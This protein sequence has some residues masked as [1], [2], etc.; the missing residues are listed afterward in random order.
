MR[1][2]QIILAVIIA[3][4]VA[5]CGGSDG[6]AGS[7]DGD[8]S[9]TT[10]AE[11]ETS[12]TSSEAD[13]DEPDEPAEEE[14][15]TGGGESTGMATVDG[16]EYVFGANGPA[17]TCDPDFFGGFFAVLYSPDLSQTLSVE[18]WP[19]GAGE[20]RVNTGTLN[21]VAPDG[22]ELDL[23]ADPEDSWPVAEAGSTFIDEFTIDGN[24]ARGTG[25]FINTEV[26]YGE[27]P[28]EPVTVDFEI[29]CAGE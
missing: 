20:G 11:Q 21:L 5:A 1:A 10:Q 14:P 24:T 4:L 19:E 23:E 15:T 13:S 2:R 27:G 7:E 22:T 6:E 12:S 25:T 16:T 28:F 9:S 26:A 17:A 29:T 3:M 8:S 18:L